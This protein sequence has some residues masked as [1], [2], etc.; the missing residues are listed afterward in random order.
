VAPQQLDRRL[1]RLL[2]EVL[3]ALLD[4]GAVNEL[5][6]EVVFVESR[7]EVLDSDVRGTGDSGSLSVVFIQTSQPPI[8]HPKGHF[9]G[10]KR[11]VRVRP[12]QEALESLEWVVRFPPNS[13]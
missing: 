6:A 9:D 1:R 13:W 3:R 5:V 11:P 4:D 8:D 2:R 10:I 7:V 12:L